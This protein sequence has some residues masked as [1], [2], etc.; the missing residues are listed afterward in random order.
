MSA[1][2]CRVCGCTDE[3]ACV[4]PAG[5][6]HWVEPD[7][8]SACAGAEAQRGALAMMPIEVVSRLDGKRVAARALVCPCGS[9]DFRVYFIGPRELQHLQ[10]VHCNETFCPGGC[11]DHAK[12]E[13]I[14]LPAA[15]APG[16]EERRIITPGDEAYGC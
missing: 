2:I 1:G 9:L 7:L 14:E 3:R 5:P 15:A 13:S 12:S 10:C 11:P 6:C 4:T 8:C 16:H